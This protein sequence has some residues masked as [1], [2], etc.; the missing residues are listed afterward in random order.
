MEYK[1]PLYQIVAENSPISDGVQ[2]TP[3]SDGVQNTPISD[4]VENTPILGISVFTA[5]QC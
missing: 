2:N 5:V 4:G 1:I 3:K